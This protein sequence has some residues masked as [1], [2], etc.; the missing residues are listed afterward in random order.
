MNLLKKGKSK[1]KGKD[2]ECKIIMEK[3]FPCF[4]KIWN[5]TKSFLYFAY[6]GFIY[7][8]KHF[9]KLALTHK[10]ETCREGE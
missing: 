4:I 3:C 1:Y 5:P 2:I 7:A 8:H 9:K 6:K 10:R